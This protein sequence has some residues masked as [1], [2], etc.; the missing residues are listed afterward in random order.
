MFSAE[1]KLL[2]FILFVVS[3]VLSKTIVPFALLILILI[4][5]YWDLH[6][7]KAKAF[8]S[9]KRLSTF[10]ILIILINT[11][12]FSKEKAWFEFY[13]FTPTLLGLKNGLIITTRTILILLYSEI[14]MQTTS[15][16]RLALA[17]EH[18][19]YPLK[20][21]F[22]PIQKL[23]MIFSL[24]LSF[25]NVLNEEIV[26]IKQAQSLR[27]ITYEKK[28]IRGRV[29]ALLSLTVPLFLSAFH[30]AD[31]LSFALESRGY[32]PKKKLGKLEHFF[33][34]KDVLFIFLILLLNG[35]IIYGG[36]YV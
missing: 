7:D 14:V 23:S 26:R 13:C 29:E 9:V 27:G 5:L 22:L 8:S 12:F 11:F 15:T 34:R 4:I 1:A 18:L 31:E 21:L 24:S 3:I 28:G 2:S 17:F 25:I 19:L 30:K 10:F 32:D 6:L 35:V 16:L 36:Y 33:S 20:Y